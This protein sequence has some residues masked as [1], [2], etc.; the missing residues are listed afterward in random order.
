V[1]IGWFRGTDPSANERWLLVVNRQF[2]QSAQVT[3]G[4]AAGRCSSV[5]RF[6]PGS[7]NYRSTASNSQLNVSLSAGQA[8][9]FHLS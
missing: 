7:T 9:L 1:I 2:D 6:D 4:L 8:A 3:L 5:A